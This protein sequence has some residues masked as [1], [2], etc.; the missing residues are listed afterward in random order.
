MAGAPR[1]CRQG[2]D[3]LADLRFGV[4]TQGS[5]RDERLLVIRDAPHRR[6]LA[7]RRADLGDRK[8]VDMPRIDGHLVELGSDKAVYDSPDGEFFAE[9]RHD[10]DAVAVLR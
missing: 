6:P 8:I 2:A 9:V 7:E 10:A 3:V 4:A 1:A 5:A